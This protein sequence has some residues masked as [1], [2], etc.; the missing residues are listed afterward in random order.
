MPYIII[1]TKEAARIGYNGFLFRIRT[2]VLMRKK[3]PAI[4]NTGCFFC[5]N[6]TVSYTRNKHMSSQLI[7]HDNDIRR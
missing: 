3:K 7:E 5:F 6:S 4:S 2:Q 1:Q